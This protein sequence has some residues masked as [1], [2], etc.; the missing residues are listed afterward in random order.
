MRRLYYLVDD[1]DTT[2]A[3]SERLHAEGITDWNFHVVSRDEAG[4]IRHD[5]HAAT[6]YQQL[7]LLHSGARFA[8]IGAA[9]GCLL[10]VVAWWAAQ[11]G[12]LGFSFDVPAIVL[13]T[14]VGALFGAWQGGMVGLSRENYKLAQ[15]HDHIAAGGYLVMVDVP[16]ARKPEVRELMSL[17]FADVAFGGCDTTWVQPFARAPR[18]Y[19]QT[20][21]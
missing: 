18:V 17:G 5:L 10:G 16:A 6:T 1:I 7:D 4:L 12:A 14:L 15:F 19:P 2:R 21:H 20:T 8:V 9:A 11:R 13:L 3:I